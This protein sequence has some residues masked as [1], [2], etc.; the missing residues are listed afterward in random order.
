M[1][2][3]LILGAF[4]DMALAI[5]RE[6]AQNGYTP[7]LAARKV[8]ERLGDAVKDLHVRYQVDARLAEFDVLDTASH[9]AFYDGLGLKPDVTVC[10]VGYLGDQARARTDFAETRKIIDTN[11]TGPVS[12]LHV[13][14]AD[15]EQRK[16]GAIIGISS[17]AGERGRQ[18]NYPYG[19]AKAA[20]TSFLSGLRNRLQPA[21]V[22]VLTVKPGFVRTKMT[23][24][25][26]LP[27]P[28]TA[29]PG[30][31]ARD[32][33]RAFARG[34]DVLYTLWMWRWIMFLIRCLPERM[35]KKMKM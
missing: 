28:V 34:K 5:A 7:I 11:Y 24:G 17:V 8:Q 32:V 2:S 12:I 20:F 3:V 18:S 1:K 6:F 30:Q 13:V 33:Y 25:M 19:S 4:S 35:F 31:V 29:D 21:G 16:A 27:P 23:E 14:A 15:Y 10:V 26:E 22:P 9:Q